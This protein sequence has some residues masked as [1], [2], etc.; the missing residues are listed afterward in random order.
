MSIASAFTQARPDLA[1][2]V[3]QW[4]RLPRR[5]VLP[6]VARRT[7]V[8]G[9]V[10][11]RAHHRGVLFK[12]RRRYALPSKSSPSVRPLTSCLQNCSRR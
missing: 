8:R 5:V 3:H 1:F 4:E 7:Q 12:Y 6:Q 9:L 11:L 10:G 2:A